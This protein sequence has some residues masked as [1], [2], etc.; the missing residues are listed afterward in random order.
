MTKQTN[1][2]TNGDGPNSISFDEFIKYLTGYSSYEQLE[3]EMNKA[4]DR[5]KGK[6][7]P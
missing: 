2:P 1:K 4:Y 3:N 5:P 6:E 7:K